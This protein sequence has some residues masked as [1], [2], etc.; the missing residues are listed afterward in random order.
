MT[1]KN[2]LQKAKLKFEQLKTDENSVLFTK[3][4]IS[5]NLLKKV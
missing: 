3:E 2:L 1:E 5:K 4:K